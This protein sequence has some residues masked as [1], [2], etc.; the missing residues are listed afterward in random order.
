MS[1]KEVAKVWAAKRLDD[2][3]RPEDILDVRFDLNTDDRGGCD[4]CGYGSS[5]PIEVTVVLNEFTKWGTKQ[6][7]YINL[8]SW[9]FTQ[10]LEELVQIGA[11]G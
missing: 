10:L 8:D 5:D 9:D 4:T 3:T 7:T 11:E 6:T 2:G 1:F